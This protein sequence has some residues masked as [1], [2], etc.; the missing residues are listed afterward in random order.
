MMY[1]IAEHTPQMKGAACLLALVLGVVFLW[2][3][4]SRR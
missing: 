1:T 4:S 2:A 3:N